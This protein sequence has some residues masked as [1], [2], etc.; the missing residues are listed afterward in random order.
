VRGGF[1]NLAAVQ[2][3]SGEADAQSDAEGGRLREL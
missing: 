2:E 1:A 3:R